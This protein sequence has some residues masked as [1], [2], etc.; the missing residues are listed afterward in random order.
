[1]KKLFSLLLALVMVGSFSIPAFAA[2]DPAL[3][4]TTRT[5]SISLYKYDVTGAEKDG[6][7]DSSYVSTGIRDESGVEAI[8]GNPAR[9]SALNANGDAYG[10][11]VRGVEFTYVKLADILAYTKTE[12]NTNRVELLYGIENSM[13][14]ASPPMTASPRRTT[15]RAARRFIITPPTC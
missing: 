2:A 9:V 3:I 10:Y 11:A 13:S 4:D 1:M 6:V 12:D 15:P 7:W 5:G 14:S 8:L